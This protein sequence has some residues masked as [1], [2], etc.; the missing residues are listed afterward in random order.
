MQIELGV[1]V[2]NGLYQGCL[3]TNMGW[4]LQLHPRLVLGNGVVRV[5]RQRDGVSIIGWW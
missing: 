3:K 2:M 1:L 4:E 5:L